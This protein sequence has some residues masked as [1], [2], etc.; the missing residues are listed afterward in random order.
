MDVASRIEE[1]LPFDRTKTMASR[2]YEGFQHGTFDVPTETFTDKH[3]DHRQQKSSTLPDLSSRYNGNAYGVN[4]LS[5]E[6][7]RVSALDPRALQKEVTFRI[8]CSNDRVGAVIGKGGSTIR[9]LQ[10]ETGA[11][12]SI[13]PPVVECEDRLITIT[14]LEVC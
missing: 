1:C 2:P 14:A 4:S 9:A 13:A 6:V 3:I 11:N 10:N 12:I 7:N 5:A 8:L